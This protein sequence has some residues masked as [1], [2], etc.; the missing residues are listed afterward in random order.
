MVPCTHEY[1]YQG[2]KQNTAKGGD[3]SRGWNNGGVWMWF[4][5]L[6][7]VY[8]CIKCLSTVVK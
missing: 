5:E 1:R 7:S 6:A 2:P 8:Y 4:E 3:L